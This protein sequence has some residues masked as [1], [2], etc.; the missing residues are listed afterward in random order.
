MRGYHARRQQAEDDDRGARTVRGGGLALAC[1]A[2]STSPATPTASAAEMSRGGGGSGAGK[3]TIVLVHGAFADATGWQEVIPLLQRRGYEVIAV[4]NP[5][6]SLASDVET[7]RRVIDARTERGP[8]VVVGHSY[9]GAV[10]TSAAAGNPNVKALVYVA[11]FAPDAGEAIGPFLEK[12]PTPLGTA[13]VPDKAG[14]LYLDAGKYRDVFAAD[15]PERETRVMAVTQKPIFGGILAE[16]STVA[17]WRT[18][19]SW[20]L[21]AERDK[22]INPELERFYARRMGARTTEIRSSHVPFLSHPQEVAKLIVDAA[23]SVSNELTSGA[24]VGGT[25]IDFGVAS[26]CHS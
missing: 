13:L 24:V 3:P 1:D 18:I 22:A 7:T 20:Y 9:G 11:A 12:Y 5:L 8:V 17:A 4:Q 16:A 19:P 14:F 23:E 10:M 2:Q 21:V 6:T 25:E 26:R 15:V